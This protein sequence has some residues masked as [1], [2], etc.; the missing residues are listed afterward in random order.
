M[1]RTGDLPLHCLYEPLDEL[2]C[3]L[4]PS[5]RGLHSLS[6]WCRPARSKVESV[7]DAEVVCQNVTSGKCLAQFVPLCHGKNARQG[8]TELGLHDRD[9]IG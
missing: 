1:P 8:D 9:R 5:M 2:Q 6:Q 4:S 7:R 3:S